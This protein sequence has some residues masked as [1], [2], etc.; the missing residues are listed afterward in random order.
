MVLNLICLWATLWKKGNYYPWPQ[1]PD[2]CN[3]HLGFVELGSQMFQNSW[4][5]FK[6][7]LFKI[8]KINSAF[9]SLGWKLGSCLALTWSG[10]ELDGKYSLCLYH[11]CHRSIFSASSF[12]HN[13]FWTVSFS[14][15]YSNSDSRYYICSTVILLNIS[16]DR[17]LDKTIPISIG[18][19]YITGPYYCDESLHKLQN[20]KV[21]KILSNHILYFNSSFCS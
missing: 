5:P 7:Q 18:V 1:G 2:S 16:A 6:T 14:S 20:Q 8:G 9:P 12:S 4:M 19:L 11:M 17:G 13:T 10:V 15:S 21:C 3:F